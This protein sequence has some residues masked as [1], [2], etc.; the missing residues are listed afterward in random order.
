MKTGPK[1]AG[2][3]GFYTYTQPW[4]YKIPLSLFPYP[5]HHDLKKF[6]RALDILRYRFNRLDCCSIALPDEPK[7]I[8]GHLEAELDA[9]E[10]VM[11]NELGVREKGKPDLGGSHLKEAREEIQKYFKSGAPAT[12]EVCDHRFNSRSWKPQCTKCGSY[13]CA[14]DEPLRV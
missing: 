11:F 13:K 4:R 5:D 6:K 7:R 8:L 2:R 1:D 14:Y 10:R 3:N 9:F 12:C